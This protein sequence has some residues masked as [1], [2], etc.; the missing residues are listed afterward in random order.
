MLLVNV[1]RPHDAFQQAQ[2]IFTI[3]DLEVLRQVGVHMMSA[4]QAVR[5]AVEGA[6][7]HTSLAGAN[8][9]FDTV[10][11]LCRRLVGESHRHDG[12]RR[13]VLYRQ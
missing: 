12:V 10:A 5:Q 13:A 1:Q 6:D 2:L 8:Q 3:Q 7:P 4:Q 11:H 9:V